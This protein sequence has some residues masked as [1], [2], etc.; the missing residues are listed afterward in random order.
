M[1]DRIVS[2]NSI[3]TP[4]GLVTYDGAGPGVSTLLQSAQAFGA[5]RP[6]AVLTTTGTDEPS[7]LVRVDTSGGAF[8]RTLPAVGASEDG[9]VIAYTDTGGQA[10]TNALT[11][12]PDTGDSIN[13]Q[14]ADA[15]Y[16]L[17]LDGGTIQLQ[18]DHANT[19][20]KIVWPLPLNSATFRLK[21]EDVINV[22]DYGA[23]ADGTTDD[24]AAFEAAL[25]AAGEGGAVDIGDGT[26]HLSGA[27]EIDLRGVTL[28]SNGA[29][30][31]NTIVVVG[32]QVQLRGLLK[33]DFSGISGTRPWYGLV[34]YRGQD[35][36]QY[37]NVYIDGAPCGYLGGGSRGGQVAGLKAKVFAE[38]CGIAFSAS[39]ADDGLVCHQISTRTFTSW[40]IT[41]AGSGYNDGQWV[42]PATGGSGSGA[43]IGITVSS[44]VVTD[45][46]FLV[47]GNNY[48]TTD[49]LSFTPADMHDKDDNAMSTG[50]GFTVRIDELLGDNITQFSNENDFAISGRESW[51]GGSAVFGINYST[52]AAYLEA[53]STY[54]QP[55]LYG[56]S[57]SLLL[58]RPFIAVNGAANNP[59]AT[60]P[61]ID[62]SATYGASRS[63]TILGG[64]VANT[65]VPLDGG[66]ADQMAQLLR[67]PASHY[68]VI[69]TEFA[70][71][72]G[73][74]FGVTSVQEA[75][76]VTLQ[77]G[78][79]AQVTTILDED[80]MSSDSATALATQQSIKAYVDANAGGTPA[81]DNDSNLTGVTGLDPWW[82]PED[83][84]ANNNSAL[85][86][87]TFANSI[88][89]WPIFFGV[90]LTTLTKLGVYINVTSASNLRL[91]L[92]AAD[93]NWSPTSL[94]VDTGS[95]STNSAGRQSVTGLTSFAVGG[96][97]VLGIQF[98]SGSCQLKGYYPGHG[99]PW[100]MGSTQQYMDSAVYGAITPFITF[101]DPPD[102]TT[103]G[104]I[105]QRPTPVIY[106]GE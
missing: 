34:S 57:T 20:W 24:L 39:V 19:D 7:Q 27:W 96:K 30:V 41:A 77:V 58:Y 53:E 49:V 60:A 88:A 87:S 23:A 99:S 45:I 21:S 86:M 47:G 78:S 81:A 38:R 48:A 72:G 37:D 13:G 22:R 66:Y 62:F 9:V 90:E 89:F 105:D 54:G 101:P 67:L 14:A 102:L 56:Q 1:V 10:G 94:V 36:A 69:D 17:D 40:T 59:G 32:Q 35:G 84:N 12:T 103:Y 42:G 82:T 43:M 2:T 55:Y 8:A 63:L 6:T 95:L 26:Y 11:I 106:V 97:M 76:A 71:S 25:T 92:Y 70:L 93:K 3:A 83:V 4:T 33:I 44:G 104:K 100:G 46:Q 65:L 91:A 74:K 5:L 29:T 16:A 50:S 28:I 80:A 73:S 15:T 18:Y 98:D 75:R 52:I 68:A 85:V 61:M 31:D 79:G 64:R 51:A